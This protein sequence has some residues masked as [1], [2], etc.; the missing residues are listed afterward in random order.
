M[1]AS[2]NT[3]SLPCLLRSERLLWR[4]FMSFAVSCRQRLE[5]N[6]LRPSEVDWTAGS[7]RT[8]LSSGATDTHC[9]LVLEMCSERVHL[10]R[11]DVVT[12]YHNK[13]LPLIQTDQRNAN[14]PRWAGGWWDL[15]RSCMGLI[16]PWRW[17]LGETISP[18]VT[19]VVKRTHKKTSKCKT[20]Q[21]TKKTN[22][23]R[24]DG[25]PTSFHKQ[26]FFFCLG[27]NT[28]VHRGQNKGTWWRDSLDSLVIWQ[29][30]GTSLQSAIQPTR[31][32]K[33]V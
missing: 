2:K 33:S 14:R 17:W 31:V 30:I 29:S 3:L 28:Y 6:L 32:S 8:L 13:D 1:K 16:S 12:Q 26:Y 11:P 4:F 7:H 9:H 22:I 25:I 20:E 19:V 27:E 21:P 10:W 23:R 18:L 24:F 15:R 5:E